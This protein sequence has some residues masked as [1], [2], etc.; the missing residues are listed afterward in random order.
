MAWVPYKSYFLSQGSVWERREE[1]RNINKVILIV[2]EIYFFHSFFL[3]AKDQFINNI[4]CLSNTTSY[5]KPSFLLAK[6]NH[7]HLSSIFQDP[8]NM[9]NDI[10]SIVPFFNHPITMWF[11]L[12]I[13]YKLSVLR[14]SFLL[15]SQNI[16]EIHDCQFG[17]L[18]LPHHLNCLVILKYKNFY[19]LDF[20][21]NS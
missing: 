15:Q 13:I 10:C 5:P 11:P 4:Q 19:P 1:G 14:I 8:H 17:F 18:C 2:I 3:E 20:L 7:T 9:S 21:T 16:I 12:T 6:T